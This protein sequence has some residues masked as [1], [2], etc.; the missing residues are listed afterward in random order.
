VAKDPVRYARDFFD[1]TLGSNG[2]N[3][4]QPGY[5]YV[6]GFGTPKL[7]NL[8]TDVQAVTPAVPAS[9]TAGVGSGNAGSGAPRCADH[10]APTSRFDRKRK[11][12]RRRLVLTGKTSDKGCG[13]HGAGA[14]RTV[15][16]SVVRVNG[17][18][19]RFMNAKGRLVK[20]VSCTKRILLPVR[21]HNSWR[22]DKRVHLPRGVYRIVARGR[23]TTGNREGA[24]RGKNVFYRRLR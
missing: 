10:K 2:L 13:V 17:K 9:G 6:T 1:V 15:S 5:D 12:S 18:R 4:A 3:P 24:H 14:V 22:F 7:A 21:G 20:R 8:L 16:V 23:D 11:V 19:C